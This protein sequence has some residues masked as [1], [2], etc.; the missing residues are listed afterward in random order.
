MKT[1]LIGLDGKKGKD[2]EV[3]SFFNSAV[4][5]DII[6]KFLESKIVQQPFGPSPVAG[7]QHSASGIINH[8][9]HVWKSA[10]GKG[11]SRI[12]RKIIMRR[13]SQFNWI[14]AEIPSTVGG[15]RAHPPKPIHFMGQ[16]K[17]NKKEA[18]IALISALSATANERF[19]KK[20]YS[21]L[22][23]KKA[24]ISLPLVIDSKINGMKTKE[25]K[26][27]LKSALDKELY[28][29]AI[30]ENNIR[31]G[32]GKLRGRKYKKNSGI[33]VVV[34][35]KEILNATGIEVKRAKEVGVKELA[36]GGPGRLTIYTEQAIKELETRI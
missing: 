18:K 27:M 24:K 32:K 31:P 8:R 25:F 16:G 36:K 22:D 19:L 21:S 23:E 11:I 1:T 5:E 20:K 12:P 4:R 2:I 29:I 6:S 17:L 3:P 33:L 28:N 15:R 9:R 10:Y 26:N 35:G 7:R 30:P 34:G 13:G 14:G